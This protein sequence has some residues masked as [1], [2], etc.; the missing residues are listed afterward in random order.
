MR[1]LVLA[2][3]VEAGRAEYALR[4]EGVLRRQQ[5]FGESGAAGGPAVPAGSGMVTMWS[6][7]LSAPLKG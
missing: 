7:P 2:V 5:A 3:A 6:R 1:H 4:A